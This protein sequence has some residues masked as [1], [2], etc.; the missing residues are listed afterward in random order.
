MM[1]T[2]STTV[3]TWGPPCDPA[4]STAAGVCVDE[5]GIRLYE[6]PPRTSPS[7]A[8]VVPGINNQTLILIAALAAIAIAIRRSN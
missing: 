7:A 4:M 6:T 1:P 3:T 2:F 8:Q 5:W